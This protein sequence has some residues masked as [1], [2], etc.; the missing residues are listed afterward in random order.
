MKATGITRNNVGQ[1]VA[2]YDGRPVSWHSGSGSKARA[3]R[4]AGTNHVLTVD[5]LSALKT[6]QTVAA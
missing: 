3:I 2:F 5:E 6:R 4:D 1:W